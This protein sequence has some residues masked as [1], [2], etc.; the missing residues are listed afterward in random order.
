MRRGTEHRRLPGL[1]LYLVCSACKTSFYQN[2][3]YFLTQYY[4]TAQGIY[5]KLTQLSIAVN[6]AW[7]PQTECVILTTVGNC[8]TYAAYNDTCTKCA[9]G[10]YLSGNSCV[11]NPVTIIKF[12]QIY[13]SNTA[14]S[15]CQQ[16]Y[17]LASANNCLPVTVIANC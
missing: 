17:Y 15:V 1:F 14:C 5:G 9:T 3:N 12:C 2:Y 4:S 7:T 13:T 6:T 11:K 8:V 10:Y 16:G